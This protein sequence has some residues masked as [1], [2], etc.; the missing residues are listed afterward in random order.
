[1]L[2]ATGQF[3]KVAC[4]SGSSVRKSAEDILLFAKTRQQQKVNNSKH[5]A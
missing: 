3:A 1:L 2:G 4:L 5:V